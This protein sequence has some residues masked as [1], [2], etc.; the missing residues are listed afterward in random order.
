MNLPTPV[1]QRIAL[2]RFA[3]ICGVVILHTPQYVPVAMLGNGGFELFKAFF[4]S[5]LF[6]ASVPVLTVISGYLLFGSGLDQRPAELYRKKFR[7]LV[8]PFLCF[9]LMLVAVA[10]IAQAR[11]GLLLSY[12]LTHSSLKQLLDATLGLTGV[13]FNYP[14]NFL[15]DL[16][17][18]MAVAPLFGFAIRKFPAIGLLFVTLLFMPDF[19]GVFLLRNSMAPLFYIGGL[20]AVYKWDVLA[21]DRYAVACVAIVFA[22][23]GAVL[24]FR[25]ANTTF[26]SFLSPFLIWP[27]ASLVKQTRLG[28]VL[29]SLSKYSLFIFVAHAPLVALSWMLYQRYSQFLSYPVYWLVTPVVVVC[30]LITIHA[31]ASRLLPTTFATMLGGSSVSSRKNRFKLGA[32]AGDRV[33]VGALVIELPAAGVATSMQSMPPMPGAQATESSEDMPHTVVDGAHDEAWWARSR[34]A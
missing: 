15:R 21:L 10:V 11:Y 25:I 19:D 8:V 26:L 32:A 18:L 1:S 30:S 9:N 3:L 20:A 34:A 7:T 23:C 17:A 29:E 22:A 5:A 13:P 31:V 33:A 16:I 14:L 24:Y 2:L 4:Q 12:D 27:A 6:R 28:R